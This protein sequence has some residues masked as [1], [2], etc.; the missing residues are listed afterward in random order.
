MPIDRLGHHTGR[1]GEVNHPR[2]RADL[3][4]VFDDVENDRDGTQT[5]KQAAR[6]I[7]LLPQIT[8]AQGNT[9]VQLARFQL[10][11]AQ[12]GSNEIRIFQRQTAIECFVYG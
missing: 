8:V 6:A 1:I 9:L 4:H 11:H 3:L 10:A 5:F 12:L 2:V 7:G